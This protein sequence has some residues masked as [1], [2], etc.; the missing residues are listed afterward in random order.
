[1]PPHRASTSDSPPASSRAVTNVRVELAKVRLS[2]RGFAERL[3]WPHWYLARRLT[4]RV[5]F[6]VDDLEAIARELGV[7]LS[8]LLAEDDRPAA[9]SYPG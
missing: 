7:P 5:A 8:Y 6:S 2:G 4:G 9:S 1:M 3:D